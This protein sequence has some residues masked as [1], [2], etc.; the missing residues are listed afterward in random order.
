MFGPNLRLCS[1]N[2]L[3]NFSLISVLS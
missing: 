3:K 1:A 2:R